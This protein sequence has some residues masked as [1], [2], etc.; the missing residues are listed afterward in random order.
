MSFIY[1]LKVNRLITK[2]IMADPI[3]IHGTGDQSSVICAQNFDWGVNDRMSSEFASIKLYDDD[4]RGMAYSIP[5]MSINLDQEM[6]DPI[7]RYSRD[8]A[9]RV[10]S[11]VFMETD[12]RRRDCMIDGIDTDPRLYS[13]TSLSLPSSAGSGEGEEGIEYYDV[14]K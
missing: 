10:D 6:P 4:S 5:E 9:P 7:R 3:V 2:S 12:Q 13:Q 11:L 14:D 8:S 1:Y